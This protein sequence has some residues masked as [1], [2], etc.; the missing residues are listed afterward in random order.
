TKPNSWWRTAAIKTLQ[1]CPIPVRPLV[2]RTLKAIDDKFW[3][4][5]PQKRVRWMGYDSGIKPG[6]TA[7]TVA[8]CTA[9]HDEAS[10]SKVE[11]NIGFYAPLK[12][13]TNRFVK[14]DGV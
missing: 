8:G 10:H 7:C 4:V 13:N 3:G 1:T 6:E 5:V 12:E 9:N 14:R 11:G 2:V